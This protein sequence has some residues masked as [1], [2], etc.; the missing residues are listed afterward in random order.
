MT[1]T[2]IL[3]VDDE[4][5]VLDG[6][7]VALRKKRAVWSCTFAT[8]G[9]EALSLINQGSFDVVVTDLRMPKINGI[10]VLKHLE[11]RAPN[12]L[13][14]ILSGESQTSIAVEAA[15]HAHQALS[16]P[17]TLP[18]LEQVIARGFASRELVGD[19]TLQKIL[20]SIRSLPP[21]PKVY[22]QLVRILSREDVSV[23]DVVG[24]V[25]AD[26][27]IAAK[28]AQLANSPF[29][30]ARKGVGN[31]TEAVT[32]L[33]F[34]LTKAIV[35]STEVFASKQ[36][37]QYPRLQEVQAHSQIVGEVA[38]ALL[39]NPTDRGHAFLAGLLH[40]VGTIVL[41]CEF[42]EMAEEAEVASI[43]TQRPIW[44]CERQL[45]GTDH[46]AVG[47]CL[48]GLW[49]LPP[50]VTEAVSKHHAGDSGSDV[51]RAVWSANTAHE[52]IGDCGSE[53]TMRVLESAR[54]TFAK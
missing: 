47:A 8:S 43:E 9:A 29:F 7:R 30:G 37:N 16:K 31:V 39:S 45:L 46:A 14:I 19:A 13:R 34:E 54:K 41:G 27:A 52:E 36:T 49:G 10:A 23:R 22:A 48:L 26:L 53:T 38:G 3:F 25:D 50:E 15:T 20:G 32:R 2:R 12:T 21:M 18:D 33:G 6:L 11:E 40:D 51:A 44:E 17:C 42:P 35:L 24:L 5:R 1:T 4:P 28:L